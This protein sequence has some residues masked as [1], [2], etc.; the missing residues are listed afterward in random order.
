MVV[1]LWGNV[2]THLYLGLNAVLRSAGHPQKAMYATIATVVINTILDPYFLFTA[3]A[4]GYKARLS[5][6]LPHR[7]SHF[8]G[9]SNCSVIKT[10]S[11]IFHK[12]IFRLKKKIVFDSLAI[13]MAPFLMN[14]AACFIVILINK[15]AETARR[16]IWLSELSALSTAWY[17][18][19][20]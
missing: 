9:N 6:R 16:G 4:G 10:N 18:F 3:S 12:G 2:I 15:G 19:S 17:S 13:G 20:L 7:S 8:S 11:C 14:L 5:L 1:I